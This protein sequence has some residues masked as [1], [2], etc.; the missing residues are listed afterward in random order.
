[1]INCVL[2]NMKNLNVDICSLIES[3]IND[4][5]Q[6]INKKDSIFKTDIS[7]TE[8]RTLNRIFYQVCKG[9]QKKLFN[10]L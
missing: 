9:Q 6:E 2:E 5:L 1:M 10:S 7:D 4:T 8:L 3:R